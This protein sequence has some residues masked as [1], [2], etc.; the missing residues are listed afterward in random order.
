M[1]I[2]RHSKIIEI[3]KENDIE[4][5]EELALRLKE[6]GFDVTQATV[7]RDIRELNLTKITDGAGRQKYAVLAKNSS[8]AA[9]RL[10]SVFST[11]IESINHAQNIIVIKTLTGMAMAVAAALDSM[12][13]SDILG[14]IAGDDTIF[15]VTKNEEKAVKLTESLKTILKEPL[16]DK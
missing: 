12:Q 16:A 6:K 11:G 1:K 7:S 2:R 4:T 10:N 13:N 8:V 15:C 9:A 3:I 5:Q 14:S